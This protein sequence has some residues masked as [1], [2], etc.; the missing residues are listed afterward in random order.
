MRQ[1]IVILCFF[2]CVSA[3]CQTGAGTRAAIS[4]DITSAII[5]RNLHMVLNHSFSARWSAE[6]EFSLPFPAPVM[7][8]EKAGHEAMLEENED[9]GKGTPGGNAL[10]FTTGVSFWP[11]KF[12]DGAYIGLHCFHDIRAGTGLAID[13]GYT[14]NVWKCLGVTAGYRLRMPECIRSGVFG[15]DGITIEIN[16]LF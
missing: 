9:A 7:N 3:F 15:T 14:I 16:Y 6:A 5:K 2:A 13:C 4:V 1:Q 10:T 11:R 8:E 12:M